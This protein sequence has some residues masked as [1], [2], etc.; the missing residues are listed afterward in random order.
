M[1][2]ITVEK[3]RFF[4]ELGKTFKDDKEFDSILFDYGLELDEDIDQ[5]DESRGE[6]IQIKDRSTSQQIRFTMSSRSSLS[7]QNIHRHLN[8]TDLYISHTTNRPTMESS[9]AKRN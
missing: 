4:R 8:R 3:E 9:C 7:T 2:T 6:A 1:P 5:T